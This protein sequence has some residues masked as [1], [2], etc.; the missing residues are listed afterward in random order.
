MRWLLQIDRRYIYIVVA[1]A[2]ISA[3]LLRDKVHFPIYASKPVRGVHDAIEKLGR[4]DVVLASLDFDPASAPELDPMARAV[5]R[6]CFSKGLRVIGM[7]HWPSGIGLA[8]QIIT[9]T[10]REFD[11]VVVAYRIFE[12]RKE[13]RAE[14]ERLRSLEGVTL[15]A[16]VA[17]WPAATVNAGRARIDGGAK[18]ELTWS[19]GLREAVATI[20]TGAPKLAKLGK[21]RWAVLVQIARKPTLTYGEDYC[22]LGQ[23]A[24]AGILIITMGQSLYAAFPVDNAGNSTRAMPM[25]QDVRSL[26]DI[27]YLICLASGN[28]GETW[29][30]YGSERYHF[31]MGIGCTAVIAPDLYPFYQAGQIT[32]IIGGI[33]GA[34]EYE[35]LIGIPGSATEAVPAQTAA[36][37]LVIVLVLLCNVGYFL[38]GRGRA[39]AS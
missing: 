16:E 30:A 39:V 6:H 4:G 29:V 13:A 34:W 5:L 20:G 36:H 37:L 3:H 10:V 2:I 7:T 23:R 26:S 1:V 12:R 31:P 18:P 17:R 32:G 19:L 38:A 25:L 22:F 24:G 21:R 33:K 8:E 27:D 14:I 35:A 28:T 15:G 9:E 11:D